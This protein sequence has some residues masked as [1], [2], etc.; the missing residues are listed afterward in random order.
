MLA[1]AGLACGLM[2]V[3]P[4][5]TAT[6][7]TG[8]GFN[9]NGKPATPQPWEPGRTN[10]WDLIVHDSD[11]MTGRPFPPG[12]AQHG[13][14]CSAYP[15]THQVTRIDDSVYICNNH[16]MTMSNT[17][18]YAETLM[19]PAHLADWSSGTVSIL[20]RVTTL[21]TTN[22][23]WI[24]ITVTPFMENLVTPID[25]S[26]DGEGMPRDHLDCTVSDS[27]PSNWSCYVR[28]NSAQQ[29]LPSGG[30]SVEDALRASGQS[31]S[32]TNRTLFEMDI[33]RTHLRFGMPEYNNW[34]VNTN[35]PSPLPYTQGVVQFGEHTYDTGKECSPGNPYPYVTCVNNSWH[36]SDFSISTTMPFTMIRPVGSGIGPIGGGSSTPTIKLAAPSPAN[37]FLRFAASGDVIEFSL[38]Q[39]GTWTRAVEQPASNV[40]NSANKSYFMPIPAGVT[41]VT[42]R[43]RDWTGGPWLVQDVSVWSSNQAALPPNS[44]APPV[45]NQPATGP[46]LSQPVPSDGSQH[47]STQKTEGQSS[48]RTSRSASPS[49]STHLREIVGDLIEH[50]VLNVG[51]VARQSPWLVVAGG[52]AALALLALLLVGRRLGSR[53]GSGKKR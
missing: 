10:D 25:N 20:F 17:G 21:R 6:A 33:S 15:A 46:I 42:F 28:T 53:R 31:P 43:G 24:G 18:G 19:T 12:I 44:N 9:W 23:D 5:Q 13:A 51:G 16:V 36:W 45:G 26:V 32:A 39:G 29:D 47:S 4:P 41:S 7:S 14:D 27:P 52:T 37:S 34:F 35:L 40:N 3:S 49:G 2:V 1:A 48:P 30:T 8:F 38:D 50:E 11:V 22:R